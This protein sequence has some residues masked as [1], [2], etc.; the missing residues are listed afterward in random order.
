MH[1]LMLAPLYAPYV[2][3]AETHTRALSEA[4]VEEGQRVSVL[5]DRGYRRLPRTEMI[6]GVCVLRTEHSCPDEIGVSR[7]D[8]VRWEAALFSLLAEAERLVCAD[9]ASR[10]DIIHA[11]C[12]ISF[13]LGAVLKDHLGCP[14]V[15]TPHETAP[16]EDGLGAARSRLLFTL[17]QIDLFVVGSRTFAEQALALGRPTDATIVVESVVRPRTITARSIEPTSERRPHATI[18]SVGRFKPRKNQLALLEA[19]AILRSRGLA[20]RYVCA[21]SCD[22]GSMSYRDELVAM[23]AKVDD[24]EVIE[25]AD[26]AGIERLFCEAD[27]VVQPSKAEGLGLLAIEALHAGIPVLATP[28]RGALE[29][30]GDYP[31]LLTRGF[32]PGDIAD[33]IQNAVDRP[34]QYGEAAAQAAEYVRRRFNPQAAAR[35][36]LDL[37]GSLAERTALA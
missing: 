22:A 35:R 24:V 25:G 31:L 27:L 32:M 29:V 12:Q 10:P 8:V 34:A 14:L 7:P 20:I 16:E 4:L 17:P 33:A 36:L 30:L 2:G 26:D 19:V 37:Y 3:G 5:T 6:N 21:G 23:A 15:V 9:P 13:L 18:L 28:T 1:I 11:Q